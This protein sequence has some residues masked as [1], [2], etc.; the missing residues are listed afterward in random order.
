MNSLFFR[1]FL[2]KLG[3]YSDSEIALLQ[4]NVEFRTL[5]KDELLLNSGEVCSKVLFI[6]K[7]AIYQYRIDNECEQH[8]IDLNIDNDWVI[9]HTSF[10]SRKPSETVIQVYEESEV[11]QLDI[12][13]IHKLIAKSQSF[14]RLGTILE[15]TTKRLKFFDSNYTPDEKYEFILQHKAQLLQ[16]FPQTLIASYLKITPETLSRVRKRIS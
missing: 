1:L 16:K 15:E 6:I 10:V 12:E 2:D 8:I 7:G 3:N 13:T 5:K 9:N 4:E 14:L 11:F